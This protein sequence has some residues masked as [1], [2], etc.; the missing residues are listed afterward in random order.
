MSET[1]RIGMPLLATSQ[2]QKE[3]THNEALIIVDALLGGVLSRTTT[4][5][6]GSPEEGDAYIVPSGA[7]GVWSDRADYVAYYFGSAW[8]FLSPTVAT[9]LPIYVLDDN[10]Y[11]KWS[12]LSPNEYIVVAFGGATVSEFTDLTD[13]PNTYSG[14]G[15]KWL[16]VNVSM[17][18]LE[19]F[20]PDAESVG[21]TP[22]VPGS[23]GSPTPGN[24]KEALDFLA[25]LGGGGSVT[26]ATASEYRIGTE[27][28]KA[29]SPDAVWDA[30]ASVAL[31][32][33]ATVA[34][35]MSTGINF[36]LTIGGNR[37]LGAPSNMKEGQTGVIA[38]TQDGTGTRTLAYNAAWVFANG[39]DPTL[40][41]VAG[42]KDLL[43]YQVLPGGTTAFGNLVKAVA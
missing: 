13:V 36:T 17:T 5:P 22:T 15:L 39:T 19:F 18:G 16:R 42:T 33:A 14:S 40:S 7:S 27:A 11:V 28:A 30:A 34:V 29:L 6:P 41:T 8:N 38:I 9:G 26:Y 10:N 43:F 1:P 32:D 4:A 37:T 23:W 35:D 25:A 21:Y 12:T 3:A 31:T 24:V 2:S 20:T